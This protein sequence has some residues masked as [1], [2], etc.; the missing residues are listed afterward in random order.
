[1]SLSDDL[2]KA[3][4]AMDAYNRGY[5]PSLK[6]GDNSDDVGTSIGHARVI[7]SKG[8]I[9]DQAAS[10]YA[11]AYKLG[12]DTATEDD[13]KTI[14]SYRGTDD[15]PADAVTGWPIGAGIY[16]ASQADMATRTFAMDWWEF[17]PET[18][19]SLYLYGERETP[20]QFSDRI[21]PA[22]AD[23]VVVEIAAPA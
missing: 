19:V 16:A 14:I 10:F 8:D 23:E 3:I 13:D 1:M 22:G 17:T 9:D 21:R 18:A 15:I 5:D 20:Q 4:L 12:S 7:D 2:F 11:I 6:L